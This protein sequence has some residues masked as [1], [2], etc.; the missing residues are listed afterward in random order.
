MRRQTTLFVL[1]RRGRT[2]SS[3]PRGFRSIA[4]AG[5]R[6][7]AFP[8]TAARSLS[9]ED[10]EWE[11]GAERLPSKQPGTALRSQHVR[12]RRRV[13]TLLAAAGEEVRPVW[14]GEA[15]VALRQLPGL[16]LVVDA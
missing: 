5:A 10:G 8:L 12:G 4:I 7:S 2:G 6:N 3:L 14:I 1:G 9:P 11:A 16:R 15:V 13:L